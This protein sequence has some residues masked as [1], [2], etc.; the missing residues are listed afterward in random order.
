MMTNIRIVT[1]ST[2]DLPQEIVEQYQIT[3]IPLT[4]MIEDKPYLDR[5]DITNDEFYV[6]L[7]GL[8]VLPTTSQP[9]PAVF[10]AAYEKLAAEGAQEIISIHISSD[11]SGT[12]QGAALA[13]KMVEDKVHVTVIDSRSATMG[14]GL[15]VYSAAQSVAAGKSI[16]EVLGLV[17][18]SVQKLDLLFLL[19][20][21]DNLQRG[22]R[23]GKASYLVGSLLNIKPILQLK[24]G[25]IHAYEKVRGNKE[26]KALERLIDDFC[27]QVDTTKP[28]YCAFGYCD[29]KELA[30]YMVSRMQERLPQ[31]EGV[32][33]QIGCVV[34][35][36]I[37]MGAVGIAFYQL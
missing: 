30:E 8:E 3:V 35:T 17:R 16:D 15:I 9:S 19:D 12:V 21:L 6:K 29:N 4:V 5:I 37:G 26:N 18:E 20:S 14:L 13:A 32:Y 27:Q 7:R 11:L 34:A 28:V 1:D 10:A 23:I 25:C 31:L 33:M 2:A 24:D 36:H 22:G